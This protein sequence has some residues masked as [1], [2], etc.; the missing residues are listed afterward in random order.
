MKFNDQ[1]GYD[2]YR[3]T[4]KFTW[5][6]CFI[7]YL[8]TQ[9]PQNGNF[10]SYYLSWTLLLEIDSEES[11]K[12]IHPCRLW[13]V[14]AGDV[15]MQSHVIWAI[16]E[17]W[18]RRKST[19]V[20]TY[21]LA[22]QPK[23]SS[24]R[25]SDLNN[26]KWLSIKINSADKPDRKDFLPIKFWDSESLLNWNTKLIVNRGSYENKALLIIEI[27]GR[28]SAMNTE[29][30]ISKPFLKYFF[31]QRKSYSPFESEFWTL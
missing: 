15:D 27:K 20:T 21:V 25:S 12:N 5:H 30:S 31:K 14:I 10:P 4:R 23:I 11:R 7:L 26:F 18:S 17:T 1:G 6:Y 13:H 2:V 9:I 19:I 8:L 28:G 29:L 24:N 3:I 16:F 22:W